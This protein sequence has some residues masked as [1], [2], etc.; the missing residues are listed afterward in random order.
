M[1]M[2]KTKKPLAPFQMACIKG[3]RL[4]FQKH[5]RFTGGYS[6]KQAPEAFI[7]GEIA[8]ALSKVA[9]YVTLESSVQ[10]LL[11]RAN[12]ELRGKKPRN[13][14]IDL[15]VWWERGTPRLVIEIKK[16]YSNDSINADAKRLRQVLRRGGS[17]REGIV[18]VY[19]DAAKVET[20]KNRFATIARRS[21]TSASTTSK[22]MP[23]VDDNGRSRYWQAACFLVKAK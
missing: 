7:Q 3:V 18:V 22:P 14:R 6:L 4:A 10:M 21:K 2:T 23:F 13:G 9:R 19:S 16:F 17:C 1:A 20:L 12:A 15:A 11:E 8:C 5:H